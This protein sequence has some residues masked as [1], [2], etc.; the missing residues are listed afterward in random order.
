VLPRHV[1]DAYLGEQVL[2]VGRYRGGGR[3]KV[4]ASAVVGGRPAKLEAAADFREEPGGPR[5]VAWLFAKEKLAYLERAL[6]LRQ[7]LSDDAYYAALDR[8]AYS[9][10][11]EITGE[12]VATSIDHG[13]QSAYASFLVLLPE[14][15]HRIDPRNAEAVAKAMERAR[16]ARAALAPDGEAPPDDGGT[17]AAAESERGG[18]PS[19]AASRGGTSYRGPAGEVP[20]GQRDPKDAQPPPENP[21]TPTTPPGGP[22]PAGPAGGIAT[23]GG[24]RRPAPKAMT[25]EN[26]LFWWAHNRDAIVLEWTAPRP[27]LAEDARAR[28]IAALE[29]TGATAGAHPAIREA[30]LIALARADGTGE[31][32]RYL[33]KHAAPKSGTAEGAVLALAMLPAAPPEVREL[34]IAAA[35]DASRPKGVRV[36]AVLVLGLLRDA[37]DE[38]FGCL[39]R[40]VR[41]NALDLSVS[42]F[43]A[44]G[45]AGDASRVPGMVGGLESGKVGGRKLR[46]LERAHLAGA[47]GRIGDARAI[48]TVLR[49]LRGKGLHARRAAAI[50]L[51]GLV[52]AAPPDRQP[53]LVGKLARALGAERDPTARNF[54]VVSL[55][56]I[57][58]DARTDVRAK[59]RCLKL[60]TGEFQDGHET[61]ERPYAALALG[62]AREGDAAVSERI[63]RALAELRGDEVALGA[64][65]ISLGLLGDDGAETTKLLARIAADRG[66]EKKLR[67]SAVVA[68]GLAGVESAKPVVRGVLMEREDRDLRIDAA[69]AARLLGDEEAEAPLIAVLTHP[70]SSQFVLAGAARALGAVGSAKSI[71]AL[72]RILEPGT[73]HGAYP[74]VTRVHAAAA[75]GRLASGG[76]DP[77]A[78]LAEDFPHRA[79]TPELGE[80]LRTP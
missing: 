22:P 67:G 80:V 26:W 15:R 10:G 30:A 77:L 9:T 6:R 4:T 55:G 23:P 31:R 19:S 66:L 57:C 50:A 47:L 69:I 49:V 78:R 74:D 45:L 48:D 62:L 60:L 41:G 65:A 61:R 70:K 56:R 39:E 44:M 52:P 38:A 42:A 40:R 21:G 16:L 51:G 29:E 72:I 2:V 12:M 13:V 17:P 71:D 46:D 53:A 75:L 8:G 79:T 14:D 36:R 73:E 24:G 35:D 34:L 76:D 37:S 64:L 33:V 5:T 43:L 68:L 7:G 11:D 18:R 25:F 27:A 3:A 58:G 54:F 28:I 63:R 59:T 20:P 1:P 32:A